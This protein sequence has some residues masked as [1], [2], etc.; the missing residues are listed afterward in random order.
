[1]EVVEIFADPASSGP[2]LVPCFIADIQNTKNANNI[3]MILSDLLPINKSGL[4]HLKRIR[5]CSSSLSIILATKNVYEALTFETQES[6]L[7]LFSNSPTLIELPHKPPESR[8]EYEWSNSIWPTIFHSRCSEEVIRASQEITE[9]QRAQFV[10]GV[11]AA[12]ADYCDA[13]L[14]GSS[15]CP[16]TGGVL[17]DPTTGK[18]VSRASEV[19]KSKVDEF[20]LQ[21]MIGHPL[22]H[23]ALLAINGASRPK[24][25]VTT[26]C[27]N[28]DRESKPLKVPK[29]QHPEN[30]GSDV[31][32]CSGLDLYIICEPCLMCGMALVHSRIR[33]VVFC[34]KSEAGALV[35]SDKIHAQSSLNHHFRAFLV[36]NV[37]GL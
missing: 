9:E 29:I 37:E 8:E 3:M 23:A 28:A 4:A 33:H 18:V 19:W 36:S 31:Y 24:K 16:R 2:K 10:V 15:L 1:M 25:H 35:S 12:L 27:L 17:V 7:N 21:K 30:L 11:N 26:L 22:C 14:E 20:G 32:L 34:K 5:K 13:D 6:I